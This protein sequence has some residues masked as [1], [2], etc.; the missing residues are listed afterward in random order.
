[1][2]HPVASE[3]PG[4]EFGIFR[5]R[6]VNDW[7][8]FRKFMG[9]VLRN[10]LAIAGLVII[11]IFLGMAVFAPIL[12]GPYPAANQN[13]IPLQPPS[14]A[15]PLGTDRI[16]RDTL[17]LLV[18]GAQISLL[19]GFAAS[20]VAMVVGTAVGLI[21]GFYGRVTDQV[22]SRA[23]D[24]FLVIPWLPFVLALVSV[25]G[26]DL[27]TV[28]FSIAVVSWPTT[29]RVIRSQVLTLKERLF[30]ERA[31]AVGARNGYIVWKHILPNVMPLVWAEAVL[32]ISS[33][34]FTEA[35]LA[36]FGLA[37]YTSANGATLVSWGSMVNDSYNSIALLQGMYWYFL[38]PGLFVTLIVL[39]FAMLGYGLE[40][41]FNPAL[42]R[43]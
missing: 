35:F 10:R 17:T 20:G 37:H 34:I 28:V 38:P 4:E 32:T 30:I 8:R 18:Y 41:I 31:R 14:A 40:E 24:F 13:G 26:S 2:A 43:R 19:V 15:H 23:T 22:L 36:F 21:A 6:I 27:S 42:R 7:K 9:Q 3:A 1:M 33:A 16:G 5:D 29:A 11:L 25:L 39:G 12:V